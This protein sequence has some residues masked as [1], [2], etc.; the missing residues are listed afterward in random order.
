MAQT[1]G[2]DSWGSHSS[3]TSQLI[4]RCPLV[5]A[6]IGGVA[7]T[8]LLDTGSMVTTITQT[9]FEQ[10]LY[11]HLQIGLQPCSWLTLKAANG[12]EIP[13]LGYLELDVHLLGR[14]LPRMG[15]LVTKNPVDSTAQS[16]KKSVPGL[17]GMNIIRN[18]YKELFID[19]GDALFQSLDVQ[20][21]GRGWQQALS[22]CQ[23]L[24]HTLETGKV[25]QVR[26]QQGPAVRVPAG[27]MKLVPATCHQGLGAILSSALLEPVSFAD[28]QLPANLLVPTAYLSVTGGSIQ[29]PVINVG[30]QDQW[31]RPKTVLG[32]LHMAMSPAPNSSIHFEHQQ[33]HGEQPNTGGEKPV[34]GQ[35]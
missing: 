30:N 29:V 27:S 28:G 32:E 19:H 35:L 14:T 13:Y 31:L 12:L 9:F 21:A 20:Q 25:G 8:C 4:G 34:P 5:K 1:L 23:Q 16:Q 2:G 3:G 7:V 15:I 17:L 24:E 18:C 6:Q 11:P 10:Q 26:V 33:A 22:E